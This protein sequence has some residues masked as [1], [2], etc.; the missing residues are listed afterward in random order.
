MVRSRLKDGRYEVLGPLWRG[1]TTEV[2][3]VL[4]PETGR[5]FAAKILPPRAASTREASFLQSVRHPA[6]LEV[7]DLFDDRDDCV[8]V[9]ELC[10]GTLAD[11]VREVACLPPRR[12]RWYGAEILGGLAAI[13]RSGI[14]HR[15]IK[16][17]N[18]F[19]ASDGSLRIG[20][21]GIAISMDGPAYAPR[22]GSS[23]FMAPEQRC[24]GVVTPAADLY[25]VATTLLWCAT[26]ETPGDLWRHEVRVQVRATLPA[27][28][29]D[30]LLRAGS[31]GA[32]E[33]YASAEEMARDL[34]GVS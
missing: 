5:E 15:D 32:A 18:I 2:L 12:L 34:A 1:A 31:H 22:A 4:E 10:V 7:V 9:T 16:P 21:F 19:I 30:V 17:H 11:L 28:L 25:G 24:Q 8:L 23:A 33:R 26:G 20:D 27:S 13:H 3:R 14:I 6:V 29:A